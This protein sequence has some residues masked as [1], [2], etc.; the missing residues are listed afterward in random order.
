MGGSEDGSGTG[1]AANDAIDHDPED[2]SAA[3]GIETAA[4]E[5]A[6]ETTT[7]GAKTSARGMTVTSEEKMASADGLVNAEDADGRHETDS[8]RR[9]GGALSSPDQT[10]AD[11]AHEA[12]AATPKSSAASLTLLPAATA[13]NGGHDQNLL[14]APAAPSIVGAPGTG[15]SNGAAYPFPSGAP[16]RDDLKASG[17]LPTDDVLRQPG[18]A[19]TESQPG[20]RKDAAPGGSNEREEKQSKSGRGRQAPERS[21]NESKAMEESGGSARP[22]D[23]D[24]PKKA[25]P[26]KKEGGMEELLESTVSHTVDCLIY[27][28][29]YVRRGSGTSSLWYDG[30]TKIYVDTLTTHV[31]PTSLSP[32]CGLSM[33]AETKTTKYPQLPPRVR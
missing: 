31:R 25:A 26:H 13:V 27:I 29:W 7:T 22:K 15:T 32:G 24:A 28:R 16:A 12:E 21:G 4:T 17:I 20:N 1:Q 3:E 11:P 23:D 8:A 2:G 18:G 14:T 5:T 6:M 10:T 30:K 33:N 9:K 19:A